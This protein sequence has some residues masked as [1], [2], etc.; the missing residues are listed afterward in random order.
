MK[1]VIILVLILISIFTC[2]KASNK[3][4]T[5]KEIFF[6]YPV[7]NDKLLATDDNKLSSLNE[8]AMLFISPGG[9]KN[10]NEKIFLKESDDNYIHIKLPDSFIKYYLINLKNK[11]EYLLVKNEKDKKLEYLKFNK[12]NKILIKLNKSVKEICDMVPD[13]R[14]SG[15]YQV[16][17]REKKRKDEKK[18]NKDIVQKLIKNQSKYDPIKNGTSSRILFNRIKIEYYKTFI[19]KNNKKVKIIKDKSLLKKIYE[20]GS[21]IPPRGDIKMK[22]APTSSLYKVILIKNDKKI[23]SIEI[24]N[25]KVRCRNKSFLSDKYR[26]VEQRFVNFIKKIFND[27]E[28]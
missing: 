27:E 23:S 25:S 19:N 10:K 9:K 12:G 18:I 15:R 6:H 13:D 7:K 20:Y 24:Y 26:K 3:K 17:L 16:I 11:N 28:L 8:R 14:K 1:K 2:L 5:I 22:L 21:D 4:V